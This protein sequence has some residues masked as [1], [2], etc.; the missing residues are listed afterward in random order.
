MFLEYVESKKRDKDID[1]IV[2]LLNFD[3]VFATDDEHNN[4][5]KGWVKNKNAWLTEVKA[6]F[7][8][9]TRNETP[10][11]EQKREA[12]FSALIN[13]DDAMTE[14]IS[15]KT[16]STVQ[17]TK[18]E[19]D[20]IM[21]RLNKAEE[22]RKAI[23]EYNAVTGYKKI[24]DPQMQALLG[25]SR[26]FQKVQ[27]KISQLAYYEK[28]E[29]LEKKNSEIH[30]EDREVIYEIGIFSE[31]C[32]NKGINIHKLKEYQNPL[33]YS[34]N[35]EQQLVER[36]EQLKEKH[37]SDKENYLMHE[38]NEIEV[39][40]VILTIMKC[41][42]AKK[43]R[44]FLNA[45]INKKEDRVAKI[46]KEAK[47]T[48]EL[49]KQSKAIKAKTERINKLIAD[50]KYLDEN[51]DINDEEA[52]KKF[53]KKVFLDA[54]N[55]FAEKVRNEYGEIETVETYDNFADHFVTIP[56]EGMKA[57][58]EMKLLNEKKALKEYVDSHKTVA[59]YEKLQNE[60]TNLKPL[61]EKSYSN[62][63][64][65]IE[66]NNAAM[67][68]LGNLIDKLP[69]LNSTEILSRISEMKLSELTE[70]LF[71]EK[72][73]SIDLKK[74]E[75]SNVSQKSNSATEAIDNI[76][77]ADDEYI[78]QIKENGKKVKAAKEAFDSMIVKNGN[79]NQRYNQ[80]QE[81]L[82]NF[83]VDCQL[84]N[85]EKD[86]TEPFKKRSI[87]FL[88]KMDLCTRS[89]HSN[90]EE[91]E[92]MREKLQAYLEK[93]TRENMLKIE[94]S[95]Q[96]YIE[97]KRNGKKNLL[98]TTEQRAFRLSFAQELMEFA[99]DGV[100]DFYAK[101]MQEASLKN[102]IEI[103]Q[104]H[105]LNNDQAFIIR[106][107]SYEDYITVQQDILL[108]DSKVNAE[109]KIQNMITEKNNGYLSAKED[110][111]EK[112]ESAIKKYQSAE[113]KKGEVQLNTKTFTKV[114]DNLMPRYGM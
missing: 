59:E 100:T 102:I 45:E 96:S 108:R 9:Y 44:E 97:A 41:E 92:L 103:N 3:N 38:Q 6:Y 65:V 95:A 11:E 66:A 33:T 35:R 63:A 21:I 7:S 60:I 109:E 51:L 4:V 77:K 64:Q 84:L 23:E 112:I 12:V 2:A 99:H 49:N 24:A 30:A 89:S 52:V 55:K 27:N 111:N 67:S 22:F 70:D 5:V 20:Q 86:R 57:Y 106:S 43:E 1:D 78:E 114:D 107:T 36:M 46:V 104:S 88:N 83:K 69:E 37:K 74:K 53:A 50:L 15:F 73:K 54:D 62:A 93:P 81:K 113:K 85:A 8:N 26:A 13:F 32:A 40:E 90:S 56:K 47:G 34:M 94:Q 76:I 101:E 42:R 105:Y 25:M 28:Y 39:E 91:F 18:E 16:D 31:E 71:K 80:L 19:W 17:H 87:E 72:Q 98:F 68:K 10:E 82:A 110:Y 61:E 75:L 29:E 58:I 48:K 14:I 79:L